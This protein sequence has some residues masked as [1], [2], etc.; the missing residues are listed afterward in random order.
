[1]RRNLWQ[2]DGNEF[3]KCCYNQVAD[4]FVRTGLS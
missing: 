3:R 2:A 4:E 1:M